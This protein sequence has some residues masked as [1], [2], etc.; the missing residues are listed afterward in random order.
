VDKE[1]KRVPE[2]APERG[3]NRVDFGFEQVTP[4][5]KN[6]RVS[7]VFSSVA[8]RYDLMNDLMSLGTHRVLKRI[9]V[10]MSGVRAGHR[11][12]DLAGGTGDFSA[13]YAPLVG[14]SGRVVLA[15]INWAM[16]ERG[17]D[18]LL[19]AGLTNVAVCQADAERLPFADASFNCVTIGFGL[20]NITDKDR[21]LKEMHRVLVPGGRLL[22]LE[23]SKATNPVIDTAYTAFQS[24]WPVMGRIVTGDSSAY[25]YLVE[26]I[27]VF[28]DQKALKQMIDDAGFA[29]SGY[30]D[31]LSGIVAVHH[32]T[33]AEAPR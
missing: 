15:D 22:V 2:R 28:P 26:S 10:E 21:A 25:R 6:R 11:V 17:R 23:F 12:L 4:R 31:L 3:P 14:S 32:G 33:K 30:D 7:G 20:R 13:H 19:D 9:T 5:E 27:R 16:T 24:L 18:R 29:S 8:E 1:P